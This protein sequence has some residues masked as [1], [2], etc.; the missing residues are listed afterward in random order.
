MT[1][2]WPK[3]SVT[4]IHFPWADLGRPPPTPRL[5]PLALL[6][7]LLCTRTFTS[8]LSPTGSTSGHRRAGGSKMI[9]LPQI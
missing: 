9:I 1:V 6:R 5:P 7:P 3:G 8:Q 2:N 4:V